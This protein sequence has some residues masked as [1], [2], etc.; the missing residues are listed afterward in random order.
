MKEN[1]IRDACCVEDAADRC[2]RHFTLFYI[3]YMYGFSSV[4]YKDMCPIP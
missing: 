4:L 2:H 1:A 3:M